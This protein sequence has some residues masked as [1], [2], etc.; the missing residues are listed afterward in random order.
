MKERFST[1]THKTGHTPPPPPPPPSTPTIITNHHPTTT[2]TATTTTTNIATTT[3]TV[4]LARL[5]SDDIFS[6]ASLPSNGKVLVIGGSYVALECA[7]FM[8][9]LGFDITV[10]CT[11]GAGVR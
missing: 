9:S 10:R 4:N 5:L 7:G 6:F 11:L 3:T 8:A 2:N 1:T